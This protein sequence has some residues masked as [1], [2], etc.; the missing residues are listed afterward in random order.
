MQIHSS[1]GMARR[2]ALTAVSAAGLVLAASAA[3]AQ[4]Y[5]DQGSSY[6]N[7]SGEQVEVTA[8]RY[9]AERG[10]N[11][12]PIR[13]VSMSREVRYDDLDL[14]TGHGARELKSRISFTARSLCERLEVAYPVAT[15]DSPPCFETA[16]K[17]AMYQANA[18]IRDARG[19]A[20]NE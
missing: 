15:S 14:R 1:L 6:Q 10:E 11:G 2:L 18:A 3:G 4:D 17:H 5:D 16:L 8:P 12:A 20:S 7:S 13:D 9:H 19:Y